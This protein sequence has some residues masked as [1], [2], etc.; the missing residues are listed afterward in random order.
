MFNGQFHP[1]FKKDVK[2]LDHPVQRELSKMIDTILENPEIG[3]A[4]SMD[5]LGVYSYHFKFSRVEY[6]IAYTILD[7]ENVFF[8]MVGVREN[9]YEVLKRRV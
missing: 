3:E 5:L 9:F 1:S 6:R 7:A 4:L 8:L 2:S